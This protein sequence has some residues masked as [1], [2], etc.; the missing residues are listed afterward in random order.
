MHKDLVAMKFIVQYKKYY[1]K[2]VLYYGLGQKWDRLI[3]KILCKVHQ[4]V[5]AG[6]IHC[7]DILFFMKIWIS[8]AFTKTHTKL[9]KNDF[10]TKCLG[11]SAML[12]LYGLKARF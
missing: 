7:Y 5:F 10:K 4:L 8:K 11:K 6:L 2:C 3:L 12:D 1:S 9:W